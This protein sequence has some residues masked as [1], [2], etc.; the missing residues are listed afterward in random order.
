MIKKTIKTLANPNKNPDSLKFRFLTDR[1][2]AE[3]EKSIL[4]CVAEEIS[5]QQAPAVWLPKSLLFK[6]EWGNY[7]SALLPKQ[8]TFPIVNVSEQTELTVSQL[9]EKIAVD[10]L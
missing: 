5:Y 8:F 6:A 9:A 4:V 10:K 1:V 3:S 7:I 2:I